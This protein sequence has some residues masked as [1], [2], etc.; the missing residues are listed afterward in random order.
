MAAS[1]FREETRSDACPVFLGM[2]AHACAARGREHTTRPEGL[3]TALKK[4]LRGL[5]WSEYKDLT[6]AGLAERL[7]VVAIDRCAEEFSE[8]ASE[9]ARL[10]LRHHEQDHVLSW[11]D[12]GLLTVEEACTLVE[13]LETVNLGH[14]EELFEAAVAADSSLSSS[15]ATRIEPLT[16]RNSVADPEAEAWLELGYDLIRRGEVAAIV[17][18]GGQGTRLGFRGPKG[19]FDIGLPSGKI[20]F[21]LFCER[22]KTIGA[23][24]Q[25]RGRQQTRAKDSVGADNRVEPNRTRPGEGSGN[26]PTPMLLV[27]TSQSNDTQTRE[28]FEENDF[29]GLA[30]DDII[31]FPQGMLPA[32]APDGKL[33]MQSGHE[34]AL[35]PDGNGGV[36]KA[37][38]VSGALDALARRGA[39]YAHVFSVDNALCRPCDPVFVGYCAQREALVGS[40]VVWKASPDEKVGV[41]AT[42]DG[43][44]GVVEY[45]ELDRHLAEARDADGKLQ[46]G[47]G[48]IC[49][50]VM[51]VDFLAKAAATGPDVLPHHV[52]KKKVPFADPATGRTLPAT[53]INAFK[54]EA[55]IFDAFALA[56]DQATLEVP[57]E[58]DFSPVKNAQGR[59]SPETARRALLDQ[60]ARWLR[61]AGAV[62]HGDHG[63]EVAPTLSYAGENLHHFQGQTLDATRAPV[64]LS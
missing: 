46:F 41:L 18:A 20:L 23:I 16:S 40:K 54:L 55:F 19:A 52:A 56:P 48:N 13:Q 34:L 45:S 2:A 33:L 61:A 32:F 17:L 5:E 62:V 44:P 29:F 6:P 14:T 4:R 58:D 31:F 28:V 38:A 53:A 15:S 60:G 26:K 8:I 11:L 25:E 10:E 30:A 39:R 50:H 9:S 36:Y 21:S 51:H 42:R 47:A 43:R 3:P 57:R 37:L 1:Q 59:D 7:G 35:A 22:L 63:V 27:M 64:Y 12:K 24:A 49:N